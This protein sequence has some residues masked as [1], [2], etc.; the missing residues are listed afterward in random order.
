MYG[1][2]KFLLSTASALLPLLAL[3]ALSV[4]APANVVIALKPDKDPDQMQQERRNF[5]EFLRS[6]VGERSDVVIPM[7]SSVILEG[8]ESRTIDVAYISSM[9]MIR[10]MKSKSAEVLLAAE[11]DGNLSY[12]SLWLTLKDRPYQSIEDLKGKPI[13]FSGRTS[14]SGFLIPKAD[15]VR[16]GLLKNKD[17]ESFF[18]RRNVW[19]GTGYV[20]AVERVLNG[21]AEAAAVSDYVFYADKHLNE[22]QKSRLKVFQTQGPVPTHVLAIRSTIEADKREKIK[23]ALL[24]LNE[25]DHHGLRDRLFN[26]KLR[27]VNPDEHLK[28]TVE[29]L[30]LTGLRSSFIR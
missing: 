26:S 12:N 20:S 14:T 13:A 4:P 5:S 25:P 15:L 8:F 9:D 29:A 19:F 27:E 18:G 21:D 2:K 24:S 6:Q 3:L 10:A 23:K 7:S 11:V 28:G 1:N 22:E 16:R 17:P 30:D